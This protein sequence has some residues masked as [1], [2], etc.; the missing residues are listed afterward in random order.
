MLGQGWVAKE[1]TVGHV[2]MPA[3]LKLC[4]EAFAGARAEI[5]VPAKLGGVS[6]CSR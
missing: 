2:A 3:E 4:T 5:L 1:G 6:P